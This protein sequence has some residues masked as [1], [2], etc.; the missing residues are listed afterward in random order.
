[1]K[2]SGIYIFAMICLTLSAFLC[3][4]Y[5]GRSIG[6]AE[7]RTALYAEQTQSTA[8]PPETAAAA[9][10]AASAQAS[11]SATI[12]SSSGTSPTE[13]DPTPAQTVAPTQSTESGKVNINTA[14]LE[15]LQTLPGIGPVLAQRILD[16]RAEHG[17][18]SSL[19]EL[20][21]VSGIGT[22]RLEA[23]LEY[24]TLGG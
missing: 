21:E 4:L 19:A 8:Q 14:T 24:I 20:T 6:G 5:A 16:Y 15:E 22:K 12:P 7:L 17:S 9:S 3:G 2:K 23:L 18:F 13:A 10:T 1:M 11:A